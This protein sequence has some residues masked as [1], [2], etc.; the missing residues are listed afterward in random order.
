MLNVHK[1]GQKHVVVAKEMKE[2][3]IVVVVAKGAKEDK[4]REMAAGEEIE[5]EKDQ[6]VI[7]AV[8]EIIDEKCG[9][10]IVI[11]KDGEVVASQEIQ[12]ETTDK[13]CR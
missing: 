12:K 4:W 6:E 10:V 11:E 1:R 8:E 3:E 2:D 9:E 13:C 7:V 5:D